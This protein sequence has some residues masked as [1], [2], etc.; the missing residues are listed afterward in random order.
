MYWIP[1]SHDTV[2]YDL[3]H[4]HP[5]EMEVIQAPAHGKPERRYLLNVQFSLHCFSR[6][7][8]SSDTVSLSY[9]DNR[10]TRAFCFIRYKYSHYLPDIIRQIAERTCYH[11]GRGN[12]LTIELMA[13]DG[14]R[15]DYEVYFQ[16][17]KSG[18]KPARLNLFVQSAYTRDHGAQFRSKI[19]KIGF[20]VIAHNTLQNKPIKVPKN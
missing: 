7:K 14:T 16:V 8:E 1:F 17:S 5:F 9:S 15:V 20:F 18:K 19:K 6:S 13:D 2:E 12:Y 4:L 3:S 11:T 10:E